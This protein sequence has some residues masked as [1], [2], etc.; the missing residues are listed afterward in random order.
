MRE[1]NNAR[2][3]D[4]SELDQVSGGVSEEIS[5]SFGQVKVVYTP[6]KSDGTASVRGGDPDEG[7]QF[8]FQARLR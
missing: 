4:L 5:L 3:I 6:Q 7:G 2:E 8:H 1:L